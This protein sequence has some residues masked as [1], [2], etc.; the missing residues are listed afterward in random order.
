MASGF[1]MGQIYVIC[2]HICEHSRRHRIQTRP[3]HELDMEDQ[4]LAQSW[5]KVQLWEN[6]H[7]HRGK[8]K[9]KV[10]RMVEF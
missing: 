1:G 6:G 7:E 9:R 2:W 5:L 3:V 10:H 4:D 8:G